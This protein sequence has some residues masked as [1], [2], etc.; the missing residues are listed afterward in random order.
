[1]RDR[2][3]V[4]VDLRGTSVTISIHRALLTRRS[5]G[6]FLR[7]QK[8]WSLGTNFL[9]ATL[10]DKVELLFLENWRDS[11]MADCR[12]L[13]LLL[14]ILVNN[15]FIWHWFR[16]YIILAWFIVYWIQ[17]TE[18][19][20]VLLAKRLERQNLSLH[21]STRQYQQT[22]CPQNIHCIRRCVAAP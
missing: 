13:W 16:V 21:N 17:H 9:T 22:N 2:V 5:L 11:T 8:L 6:N 1:M 18:K 10:Q 12:F 4:N 20:E 7:S 19:S 3:V 14:D 15:S